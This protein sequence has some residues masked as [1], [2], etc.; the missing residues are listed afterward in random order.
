M[1]RLILILAILS[2]LACST[3][4]IGNNTT[5]IGQLQSDL[6]TL[7]ISCDRC[8]DGQQDFCKGDPCAQ[9]SIKAAELRRLLK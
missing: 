1:K 6:V 7:T 2:M 4:G 5:S 8:R 9:V 3:L